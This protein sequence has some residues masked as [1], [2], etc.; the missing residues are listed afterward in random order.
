MEAEME[1]EMGAEI[2]AEMAVP[3]SLKAISSR[4]SLALAA[5]SGVV[6]GVARRRRAAATPRRSLRT[7]AAPVPSSQWPAL[8]GCVLSAKKAPSPQSHLG[9]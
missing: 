1:V 9:S 3:L 2:E 5:P 4:R 7:A 8:F 6:S